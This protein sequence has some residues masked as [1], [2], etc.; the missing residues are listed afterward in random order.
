STY[1]DMP[2]FCP[3]ALSIRG[4]PVPGSRRERRRDGF[5]D[6]MEPRRH[7]T[8]RLLHLGD[9]REH[10]AFPICLVR[11]PATARA[12]LQFLGALP[13]RG[14]FLVRESL[15]RLAGGALGRLLGALRVGEFA[16]S[17]LFRHQRLLSGSLCSA[18]LVMNGPRCCAARQREGTGYRMHATMPWCV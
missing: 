12:R 11:A 7:S 1:S 16:R 13:H 5:D 14:S 2:E 10:V 9:L 6:G 4:H 3:L 17:F 8:I 18:E 15:G